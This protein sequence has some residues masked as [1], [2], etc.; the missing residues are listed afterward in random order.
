MVHQKCHSILKKLS[1]S[2]YWKVCRG[3]YT[4]E[5][6][7]GER[8]CQGGERLWNIRIWI[9]K[10]LPRMVHCRGL[11]W[12]EAVS[13]WWEAISY[14]RILYIKS[15]ESTAQKVMEWQH[16]HRVQHGKENA[17][18]VSINSNF[19]SWSW[20]VDLTI[21]T[22]RFVHLF[23]SWYFLLAG[24]SNRVADSW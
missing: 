15:C 9:F 20:V 14:Y 18:L 12:R 16:I 11:R 6:Q 4:A 5:D 24:L 7:G 2:E 13:R 22:S 19:L 10:S 17:A 21:V 1:I 3:W 23:F 8:Q